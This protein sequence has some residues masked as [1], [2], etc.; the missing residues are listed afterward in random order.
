MTCNSIIPSNDVYDF[1]V[2]NDVLTPPFQ[3]PICIQPINEIYSIWY[4]D[5]AGLPPLSI[6]AY[7]YGSILCLS[8]V[9][10]ENFISHQA[11]YKR[12]TLIDFVD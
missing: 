5:K 8:S 7:S 2:M 10:Q 1:I 4:Y 11:V 12:P 9:T 3:T 6:G